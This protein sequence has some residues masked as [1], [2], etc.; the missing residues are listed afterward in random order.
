[1]TNAHESMDPHGQLVVTE[2]ISSANTD[3]SR[4]TGAESKTK[5]LDGEKMEFQ[6]VQTRLGKGKAH[7]AVTDSYGTWM[8]PLTLTVSVASPHH[9]ISRTSSRGQDEGKEHDDLSTDVSSVDPAGRK[10]YHSQDCELGTITTFVNL[11]LS[12]VSN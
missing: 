9:E 12:L 1:M 3:S 5:Q 4:L 6:L 11:R 2:Q 7:M 8:T 10:F